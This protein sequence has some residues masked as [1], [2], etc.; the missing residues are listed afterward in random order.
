MKSLARGEHTT[1][2]YRSVSSVSHSCLHA[3]SYRE[4]QPGVKGR[5]AGEELID[6]EFEH[7]IGHQDGSEVLQARARQTLALF[8]GKTYHP[9]LVDAT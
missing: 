9:E 5:E 4:V 1:Y 6:V 3:P 2:H 7:F 8:E